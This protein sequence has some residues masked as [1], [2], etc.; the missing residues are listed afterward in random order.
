MRN[1]LLAAVCICLLGTGLAAIEKCSEAQTISGKETCNYCEPGYIRNSDGTS[2]NACSAGC[3][4]CTG[5]TCK[6]CADNR[7]LSSGQCLF[8]D[9]TSDGA[10]SFCKTCDGA[11]CKTCLSGFFLD[12]GKKCQSC[13]D[14]CLSC[15]SSTVCTSCAKGYSLKK[16]T[17]NKV[18]KAT[19]VPSGTLDDSNKLGWFGITLL[20][21]GG[22]ILLAAL[23]GSIYCC[24]S[25]AKAEPN[26]YKELNSPPANPQ[27]TPAAQPPSGQPA[28]AK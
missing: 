28:G 8:C 10:I 26:P 22:V 23:A 17:V 27:P 13:S 3:K 5:A 24:I 14:A 9:T 2:C 7:Y 1:Y 20:V 18:D 21:I 4:E 12:T 11:A 19:C 15:T 6:T 25:H 16:E